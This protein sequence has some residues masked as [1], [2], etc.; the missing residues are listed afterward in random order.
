MAFLH[1]QKTTALRAYATIAVRQ[2]IIENIMQVNEKL[3]I[4]TCNL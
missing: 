3:V 2:Y 1:Y 4:S